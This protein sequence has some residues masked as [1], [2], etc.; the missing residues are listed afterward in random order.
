MVNFGVKL[1]SVDICKFTIV[2]EMVYDLIIALGYHKKVLFFDIKSLDISLLELA[3][4]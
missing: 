2:I 4:R 1:L 3:S